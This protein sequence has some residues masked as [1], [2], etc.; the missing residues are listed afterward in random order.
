M[1][2]IP[3]ATPTRRPCRGALA[4]VL[5]AALLL[6]GA[7]GA[8]AADSTPKPGPKF[9]EFAKAWQAGSSDG[10]ARC[11]EAKQAVSFKLLAYPLSGKARSMRPEQARATLKAYF[12]RLSGLALKD[13][14]PKRS[15]ASVRIYEY[16]YR[17][18][19]QNSQKTRLQVQLK[20]DRN[21]QWVLASVT[22][23]RGR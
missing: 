1:P 13:V 7:A 4:C 11:M 18:A 3:T 6:V 17:P 15:P 21:R 19:G 23:S 20:Q 10:V 22:E 14:T 16:S 8:D 9:A 12:K 2:P 5:V